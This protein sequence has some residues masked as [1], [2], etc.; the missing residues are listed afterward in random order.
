MNTLLQ[1]KEQKPALWEM[2]IYKCM[3]PL[4]YVT[5]N[6]VSASF[7]FHINSW[8]LELAEHLKVMAM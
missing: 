6:K 5:E 8:T 1:G 4:Y 7:Y 3:L 2:V